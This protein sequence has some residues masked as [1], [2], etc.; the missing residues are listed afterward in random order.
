MTRDTTEAA[1]TMPASA[2]LERPEGAVVET[3]AEMVVTEVTV[4]VMPGTV[5]KKVVAAV[6]F[7]TEV[8][9][10]APAVIAAAAVAA[11]MVNA[12]LTEPAVTVTSKAGSKAHTSKRRP[13]YACLAICAI[14]AI[15]ARIRERRARERG[16]CASSRT[17]IQ[18]PDPSSDPLCF[19][20]LA[21]HT[22]IVHLLRDERGQQGS[23]VFGVFASEH[24]CARHTSPSPTAPRHLSAARIDAATL[25]LLAFGVVNVR[26]LAAFHCIPQFGQ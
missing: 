16:L 7:A 22:S 12:M 13:R 24:G 23:R 19:A 4:M 21:S 10:A 1:M 8:W 20:S 9:T 3:G 15:F 2:P 5:E 18:R 26:W 14:F 11:V 25:Q 17:P 6:A